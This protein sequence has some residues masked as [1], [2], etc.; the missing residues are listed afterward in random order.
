M[1]HRCLGHSPGCPAVGSAVL[2]RRIVVI[3]TDEISC[4]NP[5]RFN[6]REKRSLFASR[7]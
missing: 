1:V 2:F 3:L 7:P 4:G 5:R 6:P